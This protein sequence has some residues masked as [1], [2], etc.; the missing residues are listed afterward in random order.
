MEKDLNRFQ[1]IPS[2]NDGVSLKQSYEYLHSFFF[3]NMFISLC[4][5]D[6]FIFWIIDLKNVKVDKNNDFFGL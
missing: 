5:K 4:C 1:F 6:S 3:L 2:V